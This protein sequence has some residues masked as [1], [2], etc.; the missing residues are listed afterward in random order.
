MYIHCLCC[1]ISVFL[2]FSFGCFLGWFIRRG[3][4]RL[5]HHTFFLCMCTLQCFLYIRD[6]EYNDRNLIT[7]CRFCVVIQVFHP[8]HNGRWPPKMTFY[9]EGLSSQILPITYFSSYLKSWERAIISLQMLSAKQGNYWYH[10]FIVSLVGR[11]PWLG[12][13]PGPLHSKPALSH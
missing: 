5:C 10:F 3:R 6:L 8:R 1:S 2:P 7:V 11:G 13:K 12:I 4:Y 9:F